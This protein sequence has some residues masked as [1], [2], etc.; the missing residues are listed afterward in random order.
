MKEAPYP[1]NFELKKWIL[2]IKFKK[3][4]KIGFFE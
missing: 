3:K 1:Q 4:F 2:A